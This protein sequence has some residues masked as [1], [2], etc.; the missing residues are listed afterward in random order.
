MNRRTYTWL[1]GLFTGIMIGAIVACPAKLIS[2][3]LS[4]ILAVAFGYM[5]REKQT[6]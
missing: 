6:K 1:S 4:L 2:V 3:L 5:G